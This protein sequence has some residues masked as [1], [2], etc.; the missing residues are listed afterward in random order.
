MIGTVIYGI[1]NI[2]LVRSETDGKKR[3]CRIKGK[4]LREAEREYSPL[5]PGDRVELTD[6]GETVA[7]IVSREERLNAFS[8]WNMKKMRPQIIAANIDM[9][10]CLCSVDQPPFRPRFLD[11]VLIAAERDG[12]HPLIC[13]NKNDLEQSAGMKSR[14]DEYAELGI[15]IAECSAFRAESTTSLKEEI[16]GKDVLFFGQSGVGKSTLINMLLPDAGRKTAE[17]S[18]KYGR[19]RHTTNYSMLLENPSGGSIIDSPG[20][21]DFFL[22]DIEPGDLAGYFRE[23]SRLEKKCRF[24]PCSHRHEPGCAVIAAKGNG[25]IHYDRYE[26]YQ[27][28]YAEL[29][30][31]EN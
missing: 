2:F 3:E 18:E 10:V 4:I 22:Y 7:M 9:I 11:R 20:V 26:S 15:P 29:I 27:R 13:V 21:R 1:N 25:L 17:I 23:F 8:R 30:N 14:L 28:I 6:I 19:G 5:V 12:I 31:R 24:N 16:K